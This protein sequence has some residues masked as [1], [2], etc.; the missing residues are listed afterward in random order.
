M[1]VEPGLAAAL[2][3]FDPPIAYL[4]FET[5]APAIP[6]WPGCHPYD[7]IPVQFSCHAQARGGG[8]RHSEWIADGP[9]DPRAEIARRVVEACADARSVAAYYSVFERDCLRRLASAVDPDLAA[10]VR[11]VE[12]RLVDPLPIVRDHVYDPDFGGSFSLKSVLPVLV[13][14]LSYDDMD[15]AEG[16][17]ATLE[18]KHL[19]FEGD[20]IEPAE[21]ARSRE[22][23]RRYCELD[24]WAMLKLIEALHGLAGGDGSGKT[25]TRR[26]SPRPR[27]L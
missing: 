24:T 15:V 17:A 12:A 13:P 19:L 27:D 1:I 3:P 26:R 23:L 14:D 5:V 22:A 16:T 18:L 2:A 20:A 7:A 21:R 8:I 9:A 10:R 25:A 6:V 11:D 4:D